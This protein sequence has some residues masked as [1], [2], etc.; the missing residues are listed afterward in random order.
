ME[1]KEILMEKFKIV[2]QISDNYNNLFWQ[3]TNVFFVIISALFAAYG[4]T[5]TKV[6]EVGRPGTGTPEEFA[7]VLVP[8]A[9][10][11]VFIGVFGALLSKLW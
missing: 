8:V 6:L 9:L 10:V 2:A 7:F 1:D 4:L 11:L 3:R 5:A